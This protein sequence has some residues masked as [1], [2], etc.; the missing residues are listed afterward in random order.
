MW[1][2]PSSSRQH[3][4]TIGLRPAVHCC[5]WGPP[6]SPTTHHNQ[7]TQP[8]KHRL[9]ALSNTA[10]PPD[11]A[12]WYGGRSHWWPLSVLPPGPLQQCRALPNWSQTQLGRQ[13]RPVGMGAAAIGGLCQSFPRPSTAVQGSP[14]LVSNTA[15]PPDKACWYGGRS[16]WWPLSVLPLYFPFLLR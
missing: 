8:L 14:Q 3:V 15:G 1:R 11:K 13:T 16:H 12:C 9:H 4:V 7:S 6:A 5:L 10:G 2:C